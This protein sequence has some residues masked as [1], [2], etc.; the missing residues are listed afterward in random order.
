MENRLD[1]SVGPYISTSHCT[2]GTLLSVVLYH[3][4][5]HG[6]RLAS[7]DLSVQVEISRSL[8]INN[9]LLEV[10]FICQVMQ[11]DFTVEH[12]A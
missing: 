7:H 6:G 10:Q 3:F 8:F 12:L 2:S 9:I 4:K 11:N 5:G 1:I